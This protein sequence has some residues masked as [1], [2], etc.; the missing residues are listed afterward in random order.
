MF[1]VDSLQPSHI[2]VLD[3]GSQLL[4]FGQAS[5]SIPRDPANSNESPKGS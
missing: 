5:R 1:E 3:I 2:L 4:I